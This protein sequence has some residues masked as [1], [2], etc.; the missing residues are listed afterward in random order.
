M[1]GNNIWTDDVRNGLLHIIPQ[2]TYHAPAEI[3]G[4]IGALRRL[5]EALI[6]TAEKGRQDASE[7]KMMSADGEGYHIVI[8]P[9]NDQ[10]M[11]RGP[12]PYAQLGQAWDF[13]RCWDCPKRS[14]DGA[15]AARAALT[16]DTT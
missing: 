15:A 5:G 6:A 3:R 9:M 13:E 7:V 14:S 4:S 8:R 12:L 16:G 1:I 11:D 2:C 10:Q